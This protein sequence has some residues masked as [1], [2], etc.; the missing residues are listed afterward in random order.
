MRLGEVLISHSSVRRFNWE[1]CQSE[2][3]RKRFEVMRATLF[4]LAKTCE[5]IWSPEFFLPSPRPRQ[6]RSPSEAGQQTRICCCAQTLQD[7]TEPLSCWMFVPCSDREDDERQI[8]SRVFLGPFWTP[9]FHL[10]P[11]QNKCDGTDT[12]QHI[13]SPLRPQDRKRARMTVADSVC[14]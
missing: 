9:D 6:S 8:F 10:R 11:S 5:K 4:W 13:A 2:W 3:Q 1:D 7:R 14:P 12:P